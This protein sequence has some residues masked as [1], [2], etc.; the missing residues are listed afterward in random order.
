MRVVKGI[1]APVSRNIGIG[2]YGFRLKA[3][4]TEIIR[5]D[6]SMSSR[7]SAPELCPRISSLENGGAQATLK[8]RGRRE[9]R[10][11]AVPAV[12]CAMCI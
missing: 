4:T 6:E 2:G 3:G 7:R 5:K 9:S 10:V 1:G 8:Y 12:S 11:H